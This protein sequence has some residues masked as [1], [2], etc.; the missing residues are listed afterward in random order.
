MEITHFTLL[1]TKGLSVAASDPSDIKT[2]VSNYGY[3]VDVSLPGQA[4]WTTGANGG[5]STNG[6]T[7]AAPVVSGGA[8]LLKAQFPF[9]TNHKL[10][11]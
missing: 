1:V 6:G 10:L 8:A 5:F 3:Y 2:I 9:Y 7:M 11:P 4:M